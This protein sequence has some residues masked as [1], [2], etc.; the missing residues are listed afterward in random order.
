MSRRVLAEA[1]DRNGLEVVTLNGFPCAGFHDEV[2]GKRVYLPDWTSP[3]RLEY[4]LDLVKVLAE[5]MPGDA[6][7]G[8]ISTLPLARLARTAARVGRGRPGL[9]QLGRFASRRGSGRCDSRPRSL[10]EGGRLG[11]LEGEAAGG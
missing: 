3:L 4:T 6:S 11:Q 9:P 1:L 8:S 10:T 7:Y 2:V 5:L